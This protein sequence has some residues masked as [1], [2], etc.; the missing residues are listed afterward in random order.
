M[1]HCLLLSK[2]WSCCRIPRFKEGTVGARALMGG[3]LGL[4]SYECAVARGGMGMAA[5]LTGR[6]A[7]SEQEPRWENS[8]CNNT[9]GSYECVCNAGFSPPV[10]SKALTDRDGVG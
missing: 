9:E 3:R 1:R 8:E 4:P 2:R 7:L 5:E 6:L 10:R